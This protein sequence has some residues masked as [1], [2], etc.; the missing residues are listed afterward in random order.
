MNCGWT[1]AKI[2][3]Q[4]IAKS[5]TLQSLNIWLN[6]NVS[7]RTWK[8][9]KKLVLNNCFHFKIKQS[10]IV[11]NVTMWFDWSHFISFYRWTILPIN[12]AGIWLVI[13]STIFWKF[14]TGGRIAIDFNRTQLNLR[15]W[16][17][18]AKSYTLNTSSI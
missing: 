13:D 12:F 3:Q 1:T 10:K 11:T 6:E 8:L 7:A 2:A 15:L 9:H 16:N 17:T 14:E 4:W 5:R 18:Q